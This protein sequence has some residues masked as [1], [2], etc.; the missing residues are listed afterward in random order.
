MCVQM[1]QG[2][3]YETHSDSVGL[4]RGLGVYIF[5]TPVMTVFLAIDHTE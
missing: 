4:E 5:N 3:Y 2:S 1:T